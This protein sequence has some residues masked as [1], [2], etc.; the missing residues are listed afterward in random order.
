MTTPRIIGQGEWLELVD[1]GGWEYLRRR[2]ST[3]IVVIIALTDDGELLLVEQPRKALGTTAIELPAGLVGDT[4]EFA[5]EET[6]IAA[7]RELEEETGYRPHELEL[8]C[9]APDSPGSS[10]ERLTVFRAGRLERVHDGGGDEHESITVHRVPL[11]QL[12]E[13]IGAQISR[14]ALVDLKVYSALALA[15]GA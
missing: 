15:R 2:R 14:G 10:S 8:I 5:G 11:D 7:A 1:D 4:R 12:H 13:W 9:I 3:G 6:R